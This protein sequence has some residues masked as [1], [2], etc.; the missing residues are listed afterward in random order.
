MPAPARPRS[1][2]SLFIAV[3]RLGA[4]AF[5]GLGAT[6]ALLQ[7]DLVDRRGWLDARD[8]KDALAFRGRDRIHRK[9]RVSAGLSGHSGAVGRCK[10]SHQIL[11]HRFDDLPTLLR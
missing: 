6:L 11:T 4:V 2:P 1:L 7:R 10:D 8:L 5:G 9:T 3:L